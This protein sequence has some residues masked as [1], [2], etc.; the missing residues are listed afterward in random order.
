MPERNFD[1]ATAI[2]Y[3]PQFWSLTHA[4]GDTTSTRGFVL[5]PEEDSQ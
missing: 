3:D 2:F 4:G 1:S 5:V